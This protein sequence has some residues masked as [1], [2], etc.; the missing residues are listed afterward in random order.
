MRIGRAGVTAR[1]KE[2]AD[3]G[4]TLEG[5]AFNGSIGSGEVETDTDAEHRVDAAMDTLGIN[6]GVGKQ[7]VEG[8]Q[9]QVA[10]RDGESALQ[11]EVLY[12]CLVGED[13]VL[14]SVVLDLADARQKKAEFEDGGS[15]GMNNL[16]T[17]DEDEAR[18][19]TASASSRLSG[20]VAARCGVR[21][22][23]PLRPPPSEAADAHVLELGQLQ[24]RLCATLLYDERD[25]DASDAARR[26]AVRHQR[27]LRQA[28]RRAAGAAAGAETRAAEAAAAARV[29]R[30][31][32]ALHALAS[33][34]CTPASAKEKE[35][36]SGKAMATVLD[37]QTLERRERELI[38]FYQTHDPVRT[39]S[40]IV[41]FLV[42]SQ[43]CRVSPSPLTTNAV[44]TLRLPQIYPGSCQRHSSARFT[45]SDVTTNRVTFVREL[46]I[47]RS[48]R[49]FDG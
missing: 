5:P 47:C 10:M 21:T 8:E 31:E 26:G 33:P 48:C 37:E 6:W 46:F 7:A 29:E 27:A 39:H 2:D 41:A 38:A 22:W 19:P 28:A 43:F 13:E 35:I 40:Y 23:Y 49:A 44:L 3:M 45:G 14:G 15:T 34:P 9:M 17:K 32:A 12:K 24:G 25:A 20:A 18:L 42:V 16:V 11:L 30:R 4:D 1:T 36:A